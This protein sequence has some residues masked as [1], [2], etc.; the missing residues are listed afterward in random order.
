MALRWDVITER[1][2]PKTLVD[3]RLFE[4]SPDEDI[5]LKGDIKI[6]NV[7]VRDERGQIVLENINLSIP[8]GARVGIK[9]NNETAA[10]AFADLLTREVIPQYLSLIHI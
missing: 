10:R 1:F 9:T 5:R 8:E 6:A 2:E 4:G 7:T 3:D